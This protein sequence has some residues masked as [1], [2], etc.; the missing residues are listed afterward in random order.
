MFLSVRARTSVTTGPGE[1]DAIGG[2]GC[3]VHRPLCHLDSTG[4]LLP[5]AA[6]PTAQMSLRE[7][8]LARESE[9]GSVNF[10]QP[11]PVKCR[12]PIEP[13]IQTFLG[14]KTTALVAMLYVGQKPRTDQ[15]PVQRR[16]KAC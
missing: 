12:T 13:N 14:P 15:A 1:L 11:C 3:S 5:A 6:A 9:Y 2:S 10:R 8:A 4:P 16:A 7:I